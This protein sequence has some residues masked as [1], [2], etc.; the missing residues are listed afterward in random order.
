MEH[1]YAWVEKLAEQYL[2]SPLNTE[3]DFVIDKL[4]KKDIHERYQ[5]ADEVLKD[6]TPK[7]LLALPPAG[8]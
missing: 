1:G 7:Q 3:L 4:L 2:R 5:S 8:N 6:L